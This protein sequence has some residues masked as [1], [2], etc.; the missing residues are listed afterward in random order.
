MVLDVLEVF[1]GSQSVRAWAD[2]ISETYAMED[3]DDLTILVDNN[4]S[5]KV[6]FAA[7]DFQVPSAAKAVEV[8]SVI[9]R[10]FDKVG[11]RAFAINVTDPQTGLDAVRLFSGTLGLL[12]TIQVTGGKAQNVLQFPTVLGTHFSAATSIGFG[13]V[14]SLGKQ[15]IVFTFNT[16]A[17][18]SVT[19][20]EAG[21]YVNLYDTGIQAVNRGSFPL[22]SVSLSTDSTY[23][24]ITVT[25]ANA[26]GVTQV[27]T[28]VSIS[29]CYFFA[30]TK[31]NI[32][33]SGGRTVVAVQSEPGQFD[34]V[35]PAT[36]PVARTSGD[37]SY[38]Q[39]GSTLSLGATASLTP[40]PMY[41]RADGKLVLQTSATH[42]LS[43]GQQVVLDDV[44]PSYAADVTTSSG[45]GR[46]SATY[47]T[48]LK[49]ITYSSTVRNFSQAVG[50]S[51]G[52]LW[53]MHGHTFTNTL[54]T[55]NSSAIL[56]TVGS[57]T[58]DAYGNPYCTTV[59]SNASSLN[60]VTLT[61]AVPLRGMYAGYA[62]S[63]G[64]TSNTGTSTFGNSG[65]YRYN[66]STWASVTAMNVSRCGHTANTYG[67]NS[68]IAAGG[69]SS[70]AN[71]IVSS[72]SIYNIG[73]NTWA[74]GPSM[75]LGRVM[76][77]SIELTDGRIVVLG[78]KTAFTTTTLPEVVTNGTPTNT[79]E[80][81]NGSAWA[82]TGGMTFS[83]HTFAMCLLP[84]GRVLVAGGYGY[85]PSLGT[86]GAYLDTI[87]IYNPS[88][89]RWRV[90]GK[91]NYA[92]AGASCVYVPSIGKVVIAGG[93][94]TSS[95]TPTTAEYWDVN[96]GQCSLAPFTT[97]YRQYGNMV[98]LDN[99]LAVHAGGYNTGSTSF[100]LLVPNLEGAGAGR[101]NGQ[102][103][104]T[105]V[106]S[107]TSLV[108][109]AG[110]SKQY[111]T[112]SSATVTPVK[113]SGNGVEGPYLL[114]GDY[115]A[116][117][118]STS[119]VT[120]ALSANQQYKTIAIADTSSFP[121]AEGWLVFNF[122][123]AQQVGPVR[124]LARIS[125]TQLLLD[126]K[127]VLS[128]DVAAGSTV[129]LLTGKGIYTGTSIAGSLYITDSSA[130]RV[131]A[132]TALS[133][134]LAAG[135]DVVAS[136]SYPG[137]RG[138]GGEGLHATGKKFSDKVT[139]W[140]GNMDEAAAAAREG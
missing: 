133:N 50:L 89:G 115:P 134:V 37:A 139:V 47:K 128:G 122:G 28:P 57:P 60:T 132:E 42:G 126:G 4:T 88:T 94:G 18:G 6:V 103:R 69:I 40:A 87:E 138:L 112:A 53:L 33:A 62:L 109:D 106:P 16:S 49:G 43:V 51:S 111:F 83:R 23:T 55:L 102:F 85:N 70:T 91:L 35:L 26:S 39:L 130:G 121:D 123:T 65:V 76:H 15:A 110:P 84:D 13:P 104:V 64:G 73:A 24:Y 17:L 56:L 127:T 21:N 48:E 74:A 93:F 67:N 7:S 97:P 113:Y 95:N 12:S 10:Y 20:P 72:T 46:T 25:I 54:R 58:N 98:L 129:T 22:E 31:K 79:C 80:I 52:R 71:V 92:R 86:A 1:Y 137:D 9:N 78:G 116:I 75:N 34:V 19:I 90:V 29:N 118:S 125:N 11:V 108:L 105:E 45:S 135:V 99:G 107:T 120:D 77:Q 44:A 131:S 61:A 81:Y 96:T 140:G 38:M 27:F 63:I 41:R 3:G 2:S 119:T 5:V 101:V 114:G 100:S 124:Y 8:A 59:L 30:A 66:G 117:T 32:Y 36:A 14:S 136:V 68:V 82:Y